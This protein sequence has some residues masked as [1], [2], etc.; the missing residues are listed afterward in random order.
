MSEHTD[1][2]KV[3]MQ[4]HEPEISLTAPDVTFELVEPS[5]HEVKTPEELQKEKATERLDAYL[6]TAENADEV[7]FIASHLYHIQPDD[8]ASLTVLYQGT[9]D[10]EPRLRNLTVLH[11]QRNGTVMEKLGHTF[12]EKTEQK[13]AKA[14]KKLRYNLG[15]VLGTYTD[16]DTM[17][18]TGWH[19]RAFDMDEPGSKFCKQ[20]NLQNVKSVE[21]VVVATMPDVDRLVEL[22]NQAYASDPNEARIEEKST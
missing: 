9:K 12:S 17:D 2:Q 3:Q 14:P 10:K 6:D 11:P 19:F 8:V 22:L 18:L 20:F 21:T 1:Q 16:P 15:A 5:E 4:E 7:R 13:Q